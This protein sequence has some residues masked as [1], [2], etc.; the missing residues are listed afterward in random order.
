VADSAPSSPS[1]PRQLIGLLA[2]ILVFALVLAAPGVA[3]LSGAGQRT[4]AVALL[5]A[6]WWITEPV[7]LAIT[8]LLPLALA[9]TLG[10]S[11]VSEVA[12]P[13]ANPVI[14]LFMGGFLLAAGLSGSGAHRR[15][16]L[17][18]MTLAGRTPEQLIAGFMVATA[19]LSMWVSN[20]AT[21]MMMLPMALSVAALATEGRDSG[22]SDRFHVAILLGVAYAANIGG[23]GTLIGT[24][25]NALLAGLM[26]DSYGIEIGFAEWMALGLPLVAVSLPLAWWLL[27]RMLFPVGREPLERGHHELVRLREQLGPVSPRERVVVA[28]V[29]VTALAWLTRPLLG[30]LIPGISDA[31]IAVAGAVLMFVIPVSLRPTR[32]ALSWR[33]AEGIPWGVLLLFGGGLSLAHLIQTSGLAQWLGESMEPAAAMPMVM[34]VVIITVVVVFLTEINSNTATA[35]TLLPIVGAL[36]LTAGYGPLELALPAALGASCAFMLPV[37]TP[38]NAIVYGSGRLTIPTMIRAGWWLNILMIGVISVVALTLGRLILG[39]A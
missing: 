8:A 19:A 26:A 25:P 18:I 34:T 28:I 22:T 29:L 35:A 14:F 12:A 27:C 1:S 15:M 2:G 39:P 7:P 21:T 24:P 32:F 11:S 37:A 4:A 16:A 20:T 36:A 6:I 5:M 17:R 33:E 9:P 23:L 38:P 13:Y 10:L 30:Q 31:G 3:H